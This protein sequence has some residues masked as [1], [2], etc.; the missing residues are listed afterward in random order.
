M[1]SQPKTASRFAEVLTEE[2]F[3][4]RVSIARLSRETGIAGSIIWRYRTGRTIPRSY[5]GDPSPNAHKIAEVL[6]LT[7]DELFGE[8]GDREK[9]A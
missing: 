7:V 3:K 5:F 2:M 6:G 9:A 8:N 4:Q 1:P